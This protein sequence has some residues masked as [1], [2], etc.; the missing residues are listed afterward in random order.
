MKKKSVSVSLPSFLSESGIFP[1]FITNSQGEIVAANKLFGQQ[2][3]LVTGETNYI[4]RLF[5][6][7]SFTPFLKS[8]SNISA[9]APMIIFSNINNCAARL[10][11]L[12]VKRNCNVQI[13][14][15]ACIN[16]L[17]IATVRCCCAKIRSIAS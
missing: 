10:P 4:Q 6:D 7:N 8:Y 16:R 15:I 2:Y 3:A 14:R 9:A 12:L 11:V 5:T 17:E 1:A 13:S